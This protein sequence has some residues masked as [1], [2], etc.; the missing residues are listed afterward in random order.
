MG[1]VKPIVKR[2]IRDIKLI[3]KG[4][5]F[6]WSELNEAGLDNLKVVRK[7][8]IPIDML[9]KT[10]IPENIEQLKPVVKEL[11]DLKKQR[12]KNKANK[13]SHHTKEQVKSVSSK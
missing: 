6:S 3:R 7:N 12:K 11:L 2:E 8:R 9:R 10:K 1:I 13:D 4:R 5:G